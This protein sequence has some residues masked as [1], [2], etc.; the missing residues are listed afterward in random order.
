MHIVAIAW[1]YVTFLMAVTE[2]SFVAGAATFL[3]YGILPLAIISYIFGTPWRK[4]RRRAAEAAAA[5]EV[6]T[7]VATEVAT[8][9]PSGADDAAA[10][11]A[12]AAE[13]AHQPDRSHAKPDQ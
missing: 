9:E 5:A 4:A 3:L 1:I 13:R 2:A 12:V 10:S 11:V 8:D 6:A 7:V